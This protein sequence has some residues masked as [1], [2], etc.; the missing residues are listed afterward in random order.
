MGHTA[1]GVDNIMTY[2]LIEPEISLWT[3][4]KVQ[5]STL[6]TPLLIC[7]VL[8]GRNTFGYK[9]ILFTYNVIWENDW[10]HTLLQTP[11]MNTKFGYIIFFKIIPRWGTHFYCFTVRAY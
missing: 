7:G 9:T 8:K 4:A 11:K 10:E 6:Y 3:T 5:A 1:P 2:I